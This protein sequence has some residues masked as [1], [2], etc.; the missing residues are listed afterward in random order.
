MSIEARYIRTDSY[1][2]W[3]LRNLAGALNY[4]EVDIVENKF[5]DEFRLA[6]ANLVANIAAGKSSS[7]FAYTGAPGTSPLPIFLANLNG[8]SAATDPSKYTGS[9]WTNSTLVQS[10]YALNPNPQTAASNLRGNATYRAN[11]V[12]AGYPANFFVVNPYVNNSTVV[13]N[14]PSTTYNG[15][16]LILNRRYSNGFQ[17]Q[18][19]YTYSKGYQSD[20][21]SFSKPYVEA[22]AEL[23]QR[24]RPAS[25]TSGTSCR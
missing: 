10:M 20:F 24:R 9:G 13:T 21:Y 15:V 11:L 25:A 23:H 3:T 14:G 6:Q 2:S 7:G 1:G 17:V 22:R 16:Q 12:A 4:N 19:S 5:I 18:A 8:S